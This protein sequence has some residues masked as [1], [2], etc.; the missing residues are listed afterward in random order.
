MLGPVLVLVPGGNTVIEALISRATGGT[1][2]AVTCELRLLSTQ[3]EQG[4]TQLIHSTLKD[5][6]LCLHYALSIV[7]NS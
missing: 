2:C 4:N 3:D 6:C 5:C 7:Y 1:Q